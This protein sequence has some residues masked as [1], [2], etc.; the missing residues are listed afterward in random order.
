MHLLMQI[1]TSLLDHN[2]HGLKNLLI[3]AA[4]LGG[5]WYAMHR[6]KLLAEEV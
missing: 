2:T 3:G 6:M 4:L 1:I 5:A